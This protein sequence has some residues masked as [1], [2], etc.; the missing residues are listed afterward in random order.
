MQ[1]EELRDKTSMMFPQDRGESDD[2]YLFFLSQ[3]L[4][5]FKNRPGDLTSVWESIKRYDGNTKRPRFA[6]FLSVAS[7]SKPVGSNGFVYYRCQCGE[8][9][10]ANSHGGCPV[11]HSTGAFWHVSRKPVQ[12]LGCQAA[13]FDCS[14]YTGMSI[15]PTCKDYG[16]PAFENCPERGRCKCMACCRFTYLQ[17]YHPERLRAGLE[18]ATRNLPAPLSESGRAFWE[19]RA[20]VKDV[21]GMLDWKHNKGAA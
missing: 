10:S 15:G 12:V 5:P 8:A 19:G 7:N 1:F 11:C 13:C 17:S 16:T 4:E 18:Q 9:L 14:I 21:N 6:F 2:E 3:A 20:S